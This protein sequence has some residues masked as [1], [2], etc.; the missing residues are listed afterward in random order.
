MDDE[1]LDTQE[2]IESSDDFADVYRT[3][4]PAIYRFLLWRTKDSM[5]SEDLTGDVF[6]R[7]WRARRRF[8]GGSVQAWLYRIARNALTDRR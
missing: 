2:M 5:L 3:H 1:P 7:A 6:M 8:H 4:S